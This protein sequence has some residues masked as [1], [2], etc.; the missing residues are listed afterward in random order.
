[1][2]D[3]ENL[4]RS[5][6]LLARLA[7]ADLKALASK[8]RV[9]SYR[10]GAVIFGQGERGDSL[11]VVVSGAVRV[12][13]LAP[14]GEEATLALLGPG[15]CVGDLSLLDGRPRSASAVAS[16]TTKTL[17]VTRNDFAQWLATRPK[18]G[19]ALL[20]TLALRVRRTDEALADLA[21]LDLPRRLAK[22]L[23]EL[24]R[25]HPEVQSAGQR[26]GTRLRITQAELAA[27]LGV[28]RESVNKQ[29][30]ALARE[31]VLQLGR[32]SVT[33]LDMNA[34]ADQV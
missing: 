8:G 16:G 12:N 2:S 19:L 5:V 6:P 33:L 15:E 30:N 17:M 7:P 23:L 3:H 29:L 31:G 27:M 24:A 9:R 21:F 25:A 1:V 28:S 4:F 22:Q 32:G 20:E 18:A 34:L 26:G 11:H 14:T 10:P 13:V